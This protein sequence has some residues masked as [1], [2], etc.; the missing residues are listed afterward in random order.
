MKPFDEAVV[1][2]GVRV[3]PAV[4]AR[5]AGRW[6]R[7]DDWLA[8]E[9]PVALVFNGISHVVM[10]AS[11]D[12]LDDFVL[13]FGLTEGLLVEQGE[14][15]GCE[16]VRTAQGI[17]LHL[18]VAAACEWRLKQRR[19]QMAGRTGCGLCGAES[20]EQVRRPLPLAPEV[21]IEADA[22]GRAVRAL[23]QW[24]AVQQLTGAAHAA[25]WCGPQGDILL[26]REDVGR[27]NALDK[28]AGAV[29]RAGMDP[30]AGWICVTSRASFEM[31]QKA[32]LLGAGMLV[33]VSAPTVFAVEEARRC[34]LALAGFARGDDLVAYVH[35]ERFG[36]PSD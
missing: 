3:V 8:E 29:A 12:H 10:L 34:G 28:L 9:V 30:A 4:T 18:D 15:Y 1:P 27:H 26:V 14:L 35:P 17:E 19:R 32:A 2:P 11:P 5:R 36:L 7:N 24:Q 6:S 21:R 25:A 16:E 13:G 20:L 33:A 22:T 23:R 31:V